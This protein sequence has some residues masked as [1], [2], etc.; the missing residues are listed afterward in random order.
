MRI[1]NVLPKPDG[2]LARL[3]PC[4]TIETAISAVHEIFTDV[5]ALSMK[6]VPL[7]AIRLYAIQLYS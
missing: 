2:P 7:L 6:T 3:I 5:R 1:Q 4:S